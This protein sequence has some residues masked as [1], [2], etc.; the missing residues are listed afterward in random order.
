LAEEMDAKRKACTDVVKLH[1]KS[2]FYNII[3]G[4]N[5]IYFDKVHFVTPILSRERILNA[6]F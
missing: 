4:N 1:S 3:F 2:E 5:S 6:K